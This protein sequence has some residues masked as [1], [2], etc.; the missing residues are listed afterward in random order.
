MRVPVHDISAP[1]RPDLPIWPGEEGLR[2]TLVATQP[3]D[4][5]NVSHLAMGAHTGTHIDAPVHFLPG[6]GGID[7]LAPD[8]FVGPCHVADLR[9]LTDTIGAGDLDE[10]SIPEEIVRILAL[11]RN[12][13]WSHADTSFRRD[14]VAYDLSAAEWCVDRGIRL[15]GIDYLSIE[16]YESDD[17]PVHKAL[18]GAGVAVLEG[19]DLFGVSPGAYHLVALP[20]LIPG[21]DG[22]PV[23]AV[24]IET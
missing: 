18:L 14:Y 5:A 10:A 11:T 15:L 2:R 12:S 17:H 7:D 1:L 21:S 20:I 6:G 19:V 22:A 23:R 9:H 3:A 8:T 16:A 24:L 4:P 13:G